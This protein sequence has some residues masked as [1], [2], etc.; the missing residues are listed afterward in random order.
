MG[1]DIVV[2]DR[3]KVAK[4]EIFDNIKERIQQATVNRIRIILIDR[5]Y[6]SFSN[7]FVEMCPMQ[8]MGILMPFKQ[9][10][11]LVSIFEDARDEKIEVSVLSSVASI[12]IDEFQKHS[13]DAN[14]KNVRITEVS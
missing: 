3:S 1:E 8:I 13:F 2:V 7:H 12:V 11:V 4:R 5:L 9:K 6:P 14:L 10:R